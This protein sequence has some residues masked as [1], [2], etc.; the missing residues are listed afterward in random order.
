MVVEVVFN[1]FK[2]K[3]ATFSFWKTDLLPA[4]KGEAWID[5]VKYERKEVTFINFFRKWSIMQENAILEHL[6]RI[7]KMLEILNSKIDN[8]LGFEDLS[9]E[10][11]K[12]LD[13]IEEEMKRGEKYP[14]E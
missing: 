1:V 5:F 9:E 11:L 3:L 4:L 2:R 14:L 13:E 12:E 10:E 8:F 6:E 7:E